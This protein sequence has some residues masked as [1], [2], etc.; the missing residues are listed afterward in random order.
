MANITKQ[1]SSILL[2][3]SSILT[4]CAII[5]VLFGAIKSYLYGKDHKT[6]DDSKYFNIT[7]VMS[8][9]FNCGCCLCV[10]VYFVWITWHPLPADLLFVLDE[11]IRMRVAT[12]VS[13]YIGKIFLFLIFNGMLYFPFRTSMYSSSKNVFVGLNVF[14]T[15][16]AISSLI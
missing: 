13:W 8:N 7:S 15:V 12:T 9:L 6:T 5:A 3:I 16:H 11:S 4:I 10:T 2:F 1:E 14:V